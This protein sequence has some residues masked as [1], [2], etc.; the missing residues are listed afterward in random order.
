MTVALPDLNERALSFSWVEIA[1][2]SMIEAGFSEEESLTPEGLLLQE[3]RILDDISI[4][5]RGI[6]GTPSRSLAT[7]MGLDNSNRYGI[8][9]DMGEQAAFRAAGLPFITT[10]NLLTLT[11]C[12][13]LERPLLAAT[14]VA[15]LAALR[16]RG[17]TMLAA[18]TG[19]ARRSLEQGPRS[20]EVFS[21]ALEA[22]L[23]AL[24]TMPPAVQLILDEID[25]KAAEAQL[26]GQADTPATSATD[27]QKR[28]NSSTTEDASP[29]KKLRGL[30][31]GPTEIKEQRGAPEERPN[32]DSGEP[33]ATAAKLRAAATAAAA[34]AAAAKA[35]KPPQRAPSRPTAAALIVPA[36]PTSPVPI[37]PADSTAANSTATTTA[38]ESAVQTAAASAAAPHPDV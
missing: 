1:L 16:T 33:P 5:Y 20:L 26:L 9:D 12:T 34:T 22:H 10:A 7:E 27:Y 13:K 15:L 29:S 14:P 35:Q 38:E 21:A 11:A 4:R 37:A 31:L 19:E 23:V 18:A 28:P 25:R 32:G 17:E 8:V 30:A 3:L 2:R 36:S 24:E 6:Q